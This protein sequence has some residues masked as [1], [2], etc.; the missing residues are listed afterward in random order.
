MEDFENLRG[1]CGRGSAVV[2]AQEA[3]VS[4]NRNVDVVDGASS[5]TLKKK[6]VDIEKLRKSS[7]NKYVPVSL[8]V[9]EAP[10]GSTLENTCSVSTC[11]R[12]L[13][14]ELNCVT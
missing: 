7:T 10:T 9:R 14:T 12:V 3:E 8:T 6:T 5:F 13:D 11:H 2:K 4:L 1:R